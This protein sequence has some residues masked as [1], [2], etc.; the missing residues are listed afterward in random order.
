MN[1][2]T[3]IITHN[4]KII[5]LD[6]FFKGKEQTRKLMAFFSFAQK[7]RMLVSLQELAYK[8]GEKK[9]VIVWKI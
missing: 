3:K 5:T 9:D 8:W 1:N 7:I 2:R 6:E 4:N